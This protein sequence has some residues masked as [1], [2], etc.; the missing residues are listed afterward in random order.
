[1][2]TST[3]DMLRESITAW[4]AR[5][6][7]RLEALEHGGYDASLFGELDALGVLH[8]L[9]DASMR[10]ALPLV[11]EAAHAFAYRSPSLALLV[12]QQNLAAYLLG[13]SDAPVPAGW[14]ALP[15]YDDPAEWPHQVQARPQDGGW[16]IDG[17][18]GSLPA[19]PYAA[20]ALLPVAH[21]EAFALLDIDLHH[22][23]PGVRQGDRAVT[24]GLRACPLGDLT[25]T[26][27]AVPGSAVLSDGPQARERI[28]RL[29]S[30]AEV[31]IQAIRSAVIAR[32]YATA[33]EYAKVR[34]QGGKIILEHTI[35]RKL[36]S[37]L[38]LGSAR[39]E[40]AWRDAC[41]ALPSDARLPAP[42]LAAFVQCAGELPR[43]A[44][45]GVQLLGG[46]GYM[47]DYGQERLFRDAKQLEMV[48][49]RPQGRAFDTWESLA[50]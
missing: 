9:H 6:E 39:H 14:A 44:S 37:G 18:W 30:Q 24:L 38:A 27:A 49:G 34:R 22:A 1:M 8:I 28:A 46:N 33:H 23:P 50:V 31:C 32:S 48:F 16:S 3:Q 10:D 36:L 5:N 35:V 42:R 7:K 12:V 13:M 26:R 43:L 20:Q 2:E 19:V 15:M 21:G 4:C 11:A 29:W 47:E 17:T 41:S 25:F 40:S 45:D